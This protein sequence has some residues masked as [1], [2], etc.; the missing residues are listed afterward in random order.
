MNHDQLISLA[1]LLTFESYP[2]CSRVPSSIFIPN[3]QGILLARH[4]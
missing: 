1:S 4:P 3:S 2:V